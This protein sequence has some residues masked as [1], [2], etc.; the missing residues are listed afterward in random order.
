MRVGEC[1]GEVM[2]DSTQQH[3]PE[4][5]TGPIQPENQTSNTTMRGEVNEPEYT[6]M[7]SSKDDHHHYDIP[8]ADPLDLTVGGLPQYHSSPL[9][10]TQVAKPTAN[11]S[12]LP[13]QANYT[14]PTPIVAPTTPDV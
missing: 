13:S 1:I 10:G 11:Q 8:D 3:T 9:P 14:V 12:S 2:N 6:Q 7:A 4:N 5:D